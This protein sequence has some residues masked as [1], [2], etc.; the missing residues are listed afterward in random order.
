ML[1]DL[2]STGRKNFSQGEIMIRILVCLSKIGSEGANSY[3]IQHLSHIK[4]Q[5]FNRFKKLLQKLIQLN[6]IQTHH[7]LTSGKSIR[8]KYRILE[9]GK[10]LV[11]MYR[12][13]IFPEIFGSID[14]V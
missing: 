11:D 12:N 2:R 1:V 8:I 6:L 5:D 4:S 10:S 7:E 9:N 14:D 13:S 3:A